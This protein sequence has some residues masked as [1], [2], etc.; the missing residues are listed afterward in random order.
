MYLTAGQ[1][2]TIQM[3]LNFEIKSGG[4]SLVHT[5]ALG[6]RTKPKFLKKIFE[7]IHLL[8]LLMQP[9]LSKKKAVLVVL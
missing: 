5:E 3:N 9:G 4:L 1:M 2:P 8:T 7:F 6:R